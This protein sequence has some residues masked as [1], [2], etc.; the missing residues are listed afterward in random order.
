MASASYTKSEPMRRFQIIPIFNEI[1]KTFLV[2]SRSVDHTVLQNYLDRRVFICGVPV[3]R[4]AV[5]LAVHDM[6]EDLEAPLVLQRITLAELEWLNMRP[7]PKHKLYRDIAT[8]IL[9]MEIVIRTKA[10]QAIEYGELQHS[11]AA[12]AANPRFF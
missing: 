1:A 11:P 8:A 9:R 10:L 3:K 4:R 7:F 12:P 5:L 2:T 6:K